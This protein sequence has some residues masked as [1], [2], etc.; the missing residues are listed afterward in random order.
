MVFLIQNNFT[1]INYLT[2]I[3]LQIYKSLI[4]HTVCLKLKFTKSKIIRVL[5]FYDQYDFEFT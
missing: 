2:L 4:L 5:L 1:K 3:E